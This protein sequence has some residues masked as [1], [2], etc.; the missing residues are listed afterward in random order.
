M[1]RIFFSLFG[2]LTRHSSLLSPRAE[3]NRQRQNKNKE[4][5]ADE[6]TA[7]RCSPDSA[8]CAF[9]KDHHHDATTSRI[10]PLSE[11]RSASV[12]FGNFYL[13][14]PSRALTNTS[15]C[16]LIQFLRRSCRAITVNYRGKIGAPY[17]VWDRQNKNVSMHI[18]YTVWSSSTTQ[19]TN[20]SEIHLWMLENPQKVGVR[21]LRK[22]PR[23]RVLRLRRPQVTHKSLRRRRLSLAQADSQS[24]T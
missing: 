5:R 14:E 21:R 1:P 12:C 23:T 19:H 11:S 2:G 15:A 13:P 16:R 4:R 7:R 3:N 9:L 22:P 18:C 24:R 8:S 6:G 20:T 17:L 10:H